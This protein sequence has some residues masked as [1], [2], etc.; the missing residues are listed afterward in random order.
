M[1]GRLTFRLSELTLSSS[2][3]GRPLHGE[4]FM[5]SLR[6]RQSARFVRPD[7]EDIF[8]WLAA[9]FGVLFTM[10]IMFWPHSGPEPI[11]MAA[12][13]TIVGKTSLDQPPPKEPIR[14]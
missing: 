11:K 4:V 5:I 12:N 2:V 3:E 10:G 13:T 7:K 9:I 6:D 1:H 14:Q 8:G